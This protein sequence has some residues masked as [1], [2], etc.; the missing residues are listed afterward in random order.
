MAR[1][2]AKKVPAKKPPAKAPAKTPAKRTA[3]KGKGP[4]KPRRTRKPTRAELDRKWLTAFKRRPNPAPDMDV[5][6]I[7]PLARRLI[8]NGEYDFAKCKAV[9]EYPVPLSECKMDCIAAIIVT[10]GDFTK[11]ADLL[12]RRELHVRQFVEMSPDVRSFW[13]EEKIRRLNTAECA[14]YDAAAEGDT[15]TGTWLLRN[16]PEE[17]VL[18]RWRTPG[19]A[20][21][22]A[23][24]S[25]LDRL[26]MHLDRLKAG[27]GM[28]DAA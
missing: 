13:N 1:A 25:I 19:I 2:A 5:T 17:I 26:K 20:G 27:Q 14:M 24:D 12:E 3:T 4:A 21:A 16:A 10:G 8:R 28:E 9:V 22:G 6:D 23:D 15:E 18:E 7:H 11:M